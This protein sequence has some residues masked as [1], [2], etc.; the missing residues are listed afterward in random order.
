MFLIC[1][2]L[3]ENLYLS[4]EIQMVSQITVTCDCYALSASRGSHYGTKSRNS[5]GFETNLMS[6]RVMDYLLGET[7][8]THGGHTARRSL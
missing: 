5:S 2:V 4:F 1:R 8:P 6:N 3:H 7:A